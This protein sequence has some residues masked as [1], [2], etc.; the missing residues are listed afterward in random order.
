VVPKSRIRP[1][2][3]TRPND[4]RALRPVTADTS[5]LSRG[6]AERAKRALN[7]WSRWK[8]LAPVNLGNNVRIVSASAEEATLIRIQ[9]LVG[10]RKWRGKVS[11]P[12][13]SSQLERSGALWDLPAS[14][15]SQF[16]SATEESDY[17]ETSYRPRHLEHL[18]YA[19]DVPPAL[20]REVTGK[21]LLQEDLS[22]YRNGVVEPDLEER[23]LKALS[24]WSSPAGDV[25]EHFKIGKGPGG[26]VSGDTPAARLVRSSLSVESIPVLRLECELGV[27]RGRHYLVEAW[28][29]GDEKKLHLRDVPKTWTWKTSAWLAVITTL[30]IPL[31]F[32]LAGLVHR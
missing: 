4:T 21:V 20:L 8:P 15:P 12:Q 28:L 31:G 3:G 11:R 13:A 29:C 19:G 32:L 6:D 23:C 26:E 1:V 14:P 17:C 10:E 30:G 2:R 22:A 25:S 18:L 5:D 16:T 9:S 27:K 24:K 7:D